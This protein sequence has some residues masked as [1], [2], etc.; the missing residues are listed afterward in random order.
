VIGAFALVWQVFSRAPV[1]VDGTVVVVPVGTSIGK[2]AKDGTLKARAGDLVSAARE[3][4]VLK[5]GGGQP[6]VV[7]R[8]G[9]EV[10]ITERVVGGDKIA[11]TPGRDVV[12]STA[13]ATVSYDAKPVY[14]GKGPLVRIDTTG[15]PGV[16]RVVKGAVSGDVV[17]TE[18]VTRAK[19]AI[20]IRSTPGGG[21]RV[22]ALT[23]DDGPWKGYTAAILATLAKYK[24]K[25]TFFTVG[26]RVDAQPALARQIVAQ[27]HTI[28]SH[29]QNHKLLGHAPYSVVSSQISIGAGE[30]KRMTGVKPRWFRPPGG[31]VSGNV[32]KVASANGMRTI[33]WDLDTGDWRKPPVMRIVDRVVNGARPGAVVLMHEGGGNRSATVAALPVILDR[34][35]KM[36]Y[37]FVTLDELYGAK[38]PAPA[39]AKPAAKTLAKPAAKKP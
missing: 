1:M 30:V 18:V 28:G 8:N 25:A 27:G 33:L 16:K 4:K 37:R 10:P 35:T 3:G 14:Y 13:A 34:L 38:K 11:S 2:L 36:G 31:S 20:Y 21:A 26:N 39:A 32:Y 7:L 19:P 29:T 17:A 23:F 6:P 9:R 22:I 5:R 12:E 24:A 15:T